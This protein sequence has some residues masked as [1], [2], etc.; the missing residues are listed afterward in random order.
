[1]EAIHSKLSSLDFIK[2]NISNLKFDRYSIGSCIA[3]GGSSLLII[4]LYRLG[5]ARIDKGQDPG[6]RDLGTYLLAGTNLL[7]GRNPYTDSN[8]RAGPSLLLFLGF[9]QKFFH[10]HTLAAAFQILIMLGV[11]VFGRYF[12]KIPISSAFPIYLSALFI[13]ATRENLVNIQ[14]TGLLLVL[15][16]TGIKMTMVNKATLNSILGCVLIGFAVDTK[17]HLF[18]LASIYLLLTRKKFR[19][20]FFVFTSILFFHVV[21]SVKIG[22]NI[23]VMW[24]NTLLGIKQIKNQGKLSENLVVWPLIERLGIS[25]RTTTYLS[26]IVVLLC[27]VA[28]FA[29]TKIKKDDELIS[30]ALA[31]VIPSFGFFFH[32]YDYVMVIILTLL[33]FHKHQSRNL[34]Y[35]FPFVLIPENILSPQNVLLVAGFIF[36]LYISKRNHSSDWQ[37]YLHSFSLWLCFGFA[38]DIFTVNISLHILQMTILSLYLTFMLFKFKQGQVRKHAV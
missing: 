4:F 29:F 30:L 14:I 6:L 36:L 22:E 10:G 11:L 2:K 9:L 19:E 37:I 33:I 13:S 26:A 16:T 12:S 15:F 18:L 8:Y 31:F 20:I 25:P 1:V 3:L 23:S 28:L 38:T 5:A 7:E 32:Y 21:S 24:L 34:V 35:L 27:V 17:P